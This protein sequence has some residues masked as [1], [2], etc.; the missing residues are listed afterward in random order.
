LERTNGG[1]WISEIEGKG[2][3]AAPVQS[4]RRAI[5]LVRYKKVTVRPDKAMI[6]DMEGSS[7]PVEIG[8]A[9]A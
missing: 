8:F 5:E 6:V 4:R 7:G 2:A 9:N 1:N 3:I